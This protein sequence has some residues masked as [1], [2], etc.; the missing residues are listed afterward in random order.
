MKNLI[1]DR[2]A[3]LWMAT[4]SSLA[5]SAPSPLRLASPG[6]TFLDIRTGAEYRSGNGLHW[7]WIPIAEELDGQPIFNP[8]F[9]STF[10]K[11]FVNKARVRLFPPGAWLRERCEICAH[12][13]RQMARVIIA[14]SDGG[15]RSETAAKLVTDAGY[16]AICVVDGGIDALL[17][18]SPLTAADKKA[19]VAR[20]EQQVGIKY[21][22]TGVTSA[23]TPDDSA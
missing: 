22:G 12:A 15:G 10:D 2:G 13:L 21:G 7:V 5:H 9:F 1:N 11:K 20:V 8:Q 6:Y 4:P 3:Q 17:Q 18:V 23:Q 19:R 16:S 14:C